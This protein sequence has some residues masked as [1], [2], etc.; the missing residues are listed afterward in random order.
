M[1]FSKTAKTIAGSL[2]AV[3]VTA[4]SIAYGTT[5]A[6]AVPAAPILVDTDL[7]SLQG[8]AENGVRSWLGVPYAAPPVDE[9]RWASAEPADSWEGVREATEFGNVCA[10]PE[11]QMPGI[12]STDEDCLYLNVYAPE[13]AREDL[14][15][16]VWFHGGGNSYGSGE[17]YDPS[18][19]V[20]EGDT[21]VVTVNYRQG[22]FG[23][24]AHPALDESGEITSGNYGLEDQQAA[25][26]WI[27]A[28]AEATTGA[29]LTRDRPN[30]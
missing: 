8:A 3:G 12:P 25:L 22:L 30:A 24:M 29:L 26:R 28:N 21:V 11:A 16:M 5:A 6:N 17:Q 27:G 9:L 15:V 2:A 23:S 14:P 13:K 7:G 19:L 4:A 10:Q 1:A 20:T 18:R